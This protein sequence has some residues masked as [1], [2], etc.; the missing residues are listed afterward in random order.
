MSQSELF[1]KEELGSGQYDMAECQAALA[2]VRPTHS[3]VRQVEDSLTFPGELV[4]VFFSSTALTV[5]RQVTA[6]SQA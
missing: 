6:G 2:P 5:G 4:V 1:P 3:S